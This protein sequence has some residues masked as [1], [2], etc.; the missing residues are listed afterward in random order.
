MENL[1]KKNQTLN[2]HKKRSTSSKDRDRETKND[3]QRDLEELEKQTSAI[4][5]LKSI[6]ILMSSY[7]S[8][9]Q[10]LGFQ[11]LKRRRRTREFSCFYFLGFYFYSSRDWIKCNYKIWKIRL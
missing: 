11:N 6:S 10:G 1:R 7:I 5:K 8:H 2:K 9:P 3:M 4:T